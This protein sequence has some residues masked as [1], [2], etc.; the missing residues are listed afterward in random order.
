MDFLSAAFDRCSGDAE[1]YLSRHQRDKLG[2]LQGFSDRNGREGGDD[3][4]GECD[5]V[6]EGK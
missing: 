4:E 2:S 1:I 5:R 3:G 6:V